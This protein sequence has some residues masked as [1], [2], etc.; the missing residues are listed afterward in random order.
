MTYFAKIH[1]LLGLIFSWIWPKFGNFS[2]LI[3][4]CTS[5]SPKKLCCDT[6]QIINWTWVSFPGGGLFCKQDL[7]WFQN[8]SR[9]PNCT[10]SYEYGLSKC[11]ICGPLP[12]LNTPSPTINTTQNMTTTTTTT[13]AHYVL[14]CGQNLGPIDQSDLLTTL[15]RNEEL[16]AVIDICKEFMLQQ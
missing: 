2:I 7:A 1:I 11:K 13:L 10:Q 3:I 14:L 8:W 15:I 5:S 6:P 16:I 12:S 4:I 9:L